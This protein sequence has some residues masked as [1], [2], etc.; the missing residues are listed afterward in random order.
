MLKDHYK[1][2]HVSGNDSIN[3]SISLLMLPREYAL[4]LQHAYII[5]CQGNNI[6]VWYAALKSMLIWSTWWKGN[7]DKN[8]YRLHKEILI[9]SLKGGDTEANAPG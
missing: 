3:H 9:L 8:K 4:F 5:F 2:L 1:V 7:P 6:T